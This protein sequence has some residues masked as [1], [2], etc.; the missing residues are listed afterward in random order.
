MAVSNPTML[1]WA[2]PTTYIDGSV[3]GQADNAG[4]QINIDAAPAVSIP[5]AWGTQFDLTTLAAFTALK[6]GTHSLTLQ[7]VSKGGIASAPSSAATFSVDIAPSA[8]TAVALA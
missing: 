8:P 1:K 4:Y 6:K 3:Y 2:N 7:A 5:L